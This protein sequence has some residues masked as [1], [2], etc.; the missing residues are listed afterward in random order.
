MSLE[1]KVG[2]NLGWWRGELGSIPRLL[3][4]PVDSV[5]L[6][7][8]VGINLGWWRGKL[9]SIPRLICLPVDSESLEFEVGV[10]LGRNSQ[11]SLLTC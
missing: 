1:Q 4:L 3:C 11:T 2:V 10:D 6:E 9:G 8:K 5:S 7:H